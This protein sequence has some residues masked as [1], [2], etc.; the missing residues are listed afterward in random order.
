[1]RLIKREENEKQL[2]DEVE[3]ECFDKVREKYADYKY[4]KSF[5]KNDW[6]K[7]DSLPNFY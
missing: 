2:S 6:N 5:I 1:M 4:M 7:F 3:Y